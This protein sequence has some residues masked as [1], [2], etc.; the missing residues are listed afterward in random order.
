MSMHLWLSRVAKEETT[1]PNRKIDLY[2]VWDGKEELPSA[3]EFKD[4]L[5]GFI[6]RARTDWRYAVIEK[7]SHSKDNWTQHHCK[8]K[9]EALAKFKALC[10]EFPR[11]KTIE[12]SFPIL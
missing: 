3:V 7:Q 2:A 12:Y 11:S 5:L 6:F 1:F 4:P 10:R 8:T 9:A